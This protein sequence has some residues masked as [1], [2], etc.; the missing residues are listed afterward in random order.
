MPDEA[1]CERVVFGFFGPIVSDFF[2]L[3]DPFVDVRNVGQVERDAVLAEPG[4]NARDLAVVPE[5]RLTEAHE[6]GNFLR[7][8]KAV[9]VQ[10]RD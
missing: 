8:V 9:R 1:L 10:I 4:V 3:T 2:T 6:R 5:L 7:G